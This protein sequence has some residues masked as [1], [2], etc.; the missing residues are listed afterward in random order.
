MRW[1]ALLPAALAGCAL[2]SRA[3]PLDV[4][5]FSPEEVEPAGASRPIAPGG[6]A[7]H[8]GR[9]TSSA[10]LRSRIVHRDSD[11]EVSE[12]E[13]LRWTESPDA[14]VTRSLRRAL[15]GDRGLRQA[16]EGSRTTLDVEVTGFEESRRG[17]RRGGRVELRYDIRDDQFVL[18]SGTVTG[19]H[20]AADNSIEQVV[21]AIA[22]A[23]HD[24]SSELAAIVVDAL[25]R[26]AR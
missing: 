3:P 23:M 22:A 5:Y 18:A 8:I 10:Y 1:V 12:Y 24:A 14:Y 21:A 9:V 20:D 13:T 11:V 7:I 25:G 19:E 2:T 4:R 26:L 17:T 6:L 15:F 16:L